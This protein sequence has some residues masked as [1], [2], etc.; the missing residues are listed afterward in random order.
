MTSGPDGEWSMSKTSI[1]DA[2]TLFVGFPSAVAMLGSGATL[3]AGA[4]PW[5]RA[6]A[7]ERLPRPFVALRRF[8]APVGETRKA[9]LAFEPG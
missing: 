4:L 8:V 3:G 5:T 7:D 9:F 2:R 1:F 6:N